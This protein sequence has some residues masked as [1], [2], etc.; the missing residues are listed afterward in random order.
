MTTLGN[1]HSVIKNS[2]LEVTYLGSA[3]D[4]PNHHCLCEL[5]SFSVLVRNTGT[6]PAPQMTPCHKE[7]VGSREAQGLAQMGAD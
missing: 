3:S 1:T 7:S 2:G 4:S 5:T 6:V